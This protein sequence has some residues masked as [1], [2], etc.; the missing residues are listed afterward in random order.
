M[1]VV[2]H[3]TCWAS[4][5][6]DAATQRQR[7]P[8][9]SQMSGL[10]I[11]LPGTGRWSWIQRGHGPRNPPFI[12]SVTTVRRQALLP[13][14][15][16]PLKVPWDLLTGCKK[17]LLWRFSDSVTRELIKKCMK[18]FLLFMIIMN[19]KT[20]LVPSWPLGLFRAQRKKQP[21]D[22]PLKNRETLRTPGFCLYLW[23]RTQNWDWGF[24]QGPVQSYHKAIQINTEQLFS[25]Y[26]V[27]IIFSHTLC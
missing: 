26:K 14:F 5:L 8:R 20:L 11:V 27:S 23:E 15:F 24:L 3:T 2:P 19:H 25:E 10:F 9:E 4:V 17:S 21:S 13:F 12:H 22:W 7:M 1:N 16:P 18:I 6:R